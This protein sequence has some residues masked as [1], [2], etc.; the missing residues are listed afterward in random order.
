MLTTWYSIKILTAPISK[1]TTTKKKKPK[2]KNK[3]PQC[4]WYLGLE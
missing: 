4:N 3:E 1:T 2:Q